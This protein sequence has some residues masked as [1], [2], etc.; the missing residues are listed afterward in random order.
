MAAAW[1]S[2]VSWH[3]AA[4]CARRLRSSCGA[5]ALLK[6]YCDT[7]LHQRGAARCQGAYRAQRHGC[8]IDLARPA[9]WCL[10]GVRAWHDAVRVSTGALG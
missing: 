4:R 9:V 2:L 10:Q 7:V 6:S 3:T 8:F 1:P 5:L